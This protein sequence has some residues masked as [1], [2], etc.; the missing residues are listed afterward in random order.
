[1]F[2]SVPTQIGYAALAGFILAESAGVPVPGETALVAASLLAGAGHL[3]LPLV[4]A[5]ATAAAI[6]GDNLGY[7]FGRRGGRAFL[8][9]EGRLSRHRQNAVRAGDRFFA[10]HGAETVLFGRWVS[11]VRIVAAVMAGASHMRWRTFLI[12]NTLGAAAWATTVAGTSALLGPVAVGIVHGGGV[13][14]AG[15]AT[16]RAWLL[17]RRAADQVQDAE[18]S[19]RAPHVTA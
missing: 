11:G 19:E 13:A 8:V 15:V 17:R 3:S 10:R 5:V 2:I 16:M 12:Y 14:A 4:I 18:T 6:V 9:R 7:A 1:M